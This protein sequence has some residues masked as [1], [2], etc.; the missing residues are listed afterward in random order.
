[1]LRRRRKKYTWMPTLGLV[2]PGLS[3]GRTTWFDLFMIPELN[4][5]IRPNQANQSLQI[6]PLVPDVTQQYSTSGSDA[7]TSLRDLTEGQDWLCKRIVGKMHIWCQG[8]GSAVAGSEWSRLMVT[9]GL[10]M[11]RAEDDAP[12]NPDLDDDEMDP[13]NLDN[14]R[15]PWMFRR[16]WLFTNPTFNVAGGAFGSTSHNDNTE[17]ASETGPHVDIRSARRIRKEERLWYAFSVTGADIGV[18]SV[19]GNKAA[20]PQIEGKIDLRILGAMRRSNNRSTF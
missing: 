14:I 7:G 15:N 20:Q 16:T 12:T 19:I 6:G 10:F 11:A 8:S 17:W 2:M 4:K 18:N 5:S 1:M 9:A 3:T 13:A